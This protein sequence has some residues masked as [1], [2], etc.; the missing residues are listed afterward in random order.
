MVDAHGWGP[1]SRKGVQVR[2]L[3]WARWQSEW[4][5]ERGEV[6]KPHFHSHSEM[7]QVAELV[8]ALHSG[9]SDRTVV[10]VRVLSWA[11]GVIFRNILSS[12]GPEAASQCQD[13][14]INRQHSSLVLLK[15]QGLILYSH[16]IL[17]H[18]SS[19]LLRSSPWMRKYAKNQ[20][21]SCTLKFA[22]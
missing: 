21:P 3:F 2:F 7:A 16:I 19:W 5:S 9:C 1:C 15:P 10:K 20:D 22:L 18:W 4:E 14:D 17:F 13:A 6:L 11:P 8:D 12:E